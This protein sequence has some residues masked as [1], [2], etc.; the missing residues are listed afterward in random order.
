MQK[1]AMWDIRG[2]LVIYWITQTKT[3]KSW[4]N[5]GIKYGRKSSRYVSKL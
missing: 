1:K 3:R 4:A 2:V 5:Q